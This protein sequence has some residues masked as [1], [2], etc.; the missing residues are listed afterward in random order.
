MTR[1]LWEAAQRRALTRTSSKGDNGDFPLTGIVRCAGCRYRLKS[2]RYTDKRRGGKR[3]AIYRCRGN[4]GAGKC[5]A[6]ATIT[7]HVL[8]DFVLGHFF[9]RIQ[10][11]AAQGIASNK[12]F[13]AAQKEVERANDALLAYLADDDVKAL[14]SKDSYLSGVKARQ[15]VLDDA[16]EALEAIQQKASG[17]TFPVD[18]AEWEDFTVA[19]KRKL[20][21]AGMDA[22]IIKRTGQAPVSERTR[23][24]WRG[25]GPDDLP[26]SGLNVP[27]RSFD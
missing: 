16:T 8:N 23:I 2:D 21:A 12:D 9:D 7:A 19:E 25:E 20:I 11:I 4:H 27:I 5:P 6:P 3:T 22:V 10:G 1:E 17:I 13:E 14:V 26:G 15:K 18:P 24:L